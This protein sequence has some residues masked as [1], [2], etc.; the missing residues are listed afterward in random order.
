MAV[1]RGSLDSRVGKGSEVH[2]S[3]RW[4]AVDDDV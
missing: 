1:E 3:G 4:V 2:G